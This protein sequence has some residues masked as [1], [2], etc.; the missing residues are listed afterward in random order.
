[1]FIGS[2]YV[3]KEQRALNGVDADIPCHLAERRRRAVHGFFNALGSGSPLSFES[4]EMP[5]W[6]P[7]TRE[8]LEFVP[9]IQASSAGEKAIGVLPRIEGRMCLK[10]SPRLY[11]AARI[12]GA[13][14][15][16]FGDDNVVVSQHEGVRRFTIL[17]TIG[18]IGLEGVLQ[19]Q[20]LW[21][22]GGEEFSRALYF[23]TQASLFDGIAGVP[24]A[25][26]EGMQFAIECGF[27]RMAGDDHF[28]EVVRP[29]V[30]WHAVNQGGREGPHDALARLEVSRMER[31]I[32][33]SWPYHELDTI[34]FTNAADFGLVPGF[35]ECLRGKRVEMVAAMGRLKPLPTNSVKVQK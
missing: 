8:T 16:A 27:R 23:Y 15:D 5:A 12:V 33:S 26:W 18:G 22:I 11:E 32:G 17:E 31:M 7:T 30:F 34:S 2:E 13:Q 29:A 6:A 19:L 3:V 20:A 21:R 35:V 25:P 4:G 1:M 9:V 14:V 10:P 28:Q 24:T